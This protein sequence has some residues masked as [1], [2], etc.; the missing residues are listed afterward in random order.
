RPT[1]DSRAGERHGAAGHFD[2]PQAAGQSDGTAENGSHGG[3]APPVRRNASVR[4]IRNVP[5]PLSAELA[6]HC[7]WRPGRSLYPGRSCLECCVY[8]KLRLERIGDEVHRGANRCVL[9]SLTGAETAVPP[10]CPN[11]TRPRRA[12]CRAR[13]PACKFATAT[14]GQHSR[15]V[16]SEFKL[17]SAAR[18]DFSGLGE[19]S[20]PAY[21]KSYGNWSGHRKISGAPRCA[22]GPW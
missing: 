12:A 16:K 1:V 9:I 8:Q 19:R 11:E 5:S 20:R 2:G 7:A 18:R 13:P 21:A 14:I 3:A 6:R 17:R 22:P 15:V 10:K 4:G